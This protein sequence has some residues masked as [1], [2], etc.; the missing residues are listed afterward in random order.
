MEA[1]TRYYSDNTSE[2]SGLRHGRFTK[3]AVFLQPMAWSMPEWRKQLEHL[4]NE[5]LRQVSGDTTT[6]WMPQDSAYL[7]VLLE[8]AKTGVNRLYKII[9]T[10]SPNLGKSGL[11]Q[12][13]HRRVQERGKS[14]QLEDGAHC[15]ASMPDRNKNER[16][17]SQ[18]SPSETAV[19]HVEACGFRRT[20]D[21]AA[22]P[23]Y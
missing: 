20:H 4:I 18:Y 6:D 5:M 11:C 2:A 9:Q 13:V 3:V 8:G 16:A 15:I 19:Q 21:I 23:L 17:N 1:A 22:K 14:A 7:G 12:D 10:M